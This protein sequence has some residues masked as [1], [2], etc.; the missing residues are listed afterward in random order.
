M[1][2]QGTFLLD[3][4]WDWDSQRETR[5]QIFA[6]GDGTTINHGTMTPWFH[7]SRVRGN[8][9]IRSRPRPGHSRVAWENVLTVWRPDFGVQQLSWQL[10]VCIWP[11]EWQIEL[12][13]WHKMK[14]RI[15]WSKL[16]KIGNNFH[17]WRPLSSYS[18]SG[19]ILFLFKLCPFSTIFC[20]SPSQ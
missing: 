18:G 9:Q 7:S 16:H 8:N 15:K 2:R 11:I 5:H 14:I 10:A 20:A 6:A 4:T 17:C 3:L 1:P 12:P 19:L 13:T